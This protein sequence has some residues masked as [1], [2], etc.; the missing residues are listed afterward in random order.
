MRDG[1]K[2]ERRM[3][4]RSRKRGTRRRGGVR[5]EEES[6]EERSGRMKIGKKEEKR[7]GGEGDMSEMGD[8]EKWTREQGEK[9]QKRY[10]ETSGQGEK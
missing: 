8:M 7:G 3:K 10:K 5:E 2:R 9:V 6:D 4:G 1:E